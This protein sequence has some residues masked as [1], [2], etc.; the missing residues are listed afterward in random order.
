MQPHAQQRK[1]SKRAEDGERRGFL[2]QTLVLGASTSYLTCLLSCAPW[3]TGCRKNV[4]RNSSRDAA[5]T[6][7]Q[8]DGRETRRRTEM[9]GEGF[10]TLP[11]TGVHGVV[12]VSH[13]LATHLKH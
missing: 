4:D 8:L 9:G 3:S 12:L 13:V 6:H 1:N 10:V 2:P 5:A 7:A 11:Q